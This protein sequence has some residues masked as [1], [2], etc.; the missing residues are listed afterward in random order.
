M[1]CIG[2]G[3]ISREETQVGGGKNSEET[4]VGG[5]KN[6]EETQVGGGKN[7]STMGIRGEP[8]VGGHYS[9][10]LRRDSM[11]SGCLFQFSSEPQHPRC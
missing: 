2:G 9:S 1:T 4:Q 7:S 5:G 11:L 6:S 8:P 10:V 3:K